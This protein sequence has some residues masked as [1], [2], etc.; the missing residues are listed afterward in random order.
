MA[1][2]EAVATLWVLSVAWMF[3]QVS[4]IWGI[5]YCVLCTPAFLS[6]FLILKWLLNDSYLNRKI[7]A[8][9]FLIKLALQAFW[10]L[11]YLLLWATAITT[12]EEER[13]AIDNKEPTAK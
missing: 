3:F 12:P 4:L 1:I 11:A 9:G 2:L 6:T 5:I 7:M 13:H 10:M 8:F